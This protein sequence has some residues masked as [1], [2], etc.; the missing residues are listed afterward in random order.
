MKSHPPKDSNL[1]IYILSPGKYHTRQTR[2]TSD[3][4]SELNQDTIRR[5][6]SSATVVIMQENDEASTPELN[7]IVFLILMNNFSTI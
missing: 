7:C 4:R 3:N 5:Q 1:H 2:I 6:Y